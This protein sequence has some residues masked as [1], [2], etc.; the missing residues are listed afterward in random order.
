MK[1]KDLKTG[2]WF[3][4]VNSDN[5]ETTITFGQ[6]IDIWSMRAGAGWGIQ[7]NDKLKSFAWGN[8]EDELPQ[9]FEF[10]GVEVF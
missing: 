8:N 6:I 5:P 4:I 1:I 10:L 7:F 9:G 3:K 2:M